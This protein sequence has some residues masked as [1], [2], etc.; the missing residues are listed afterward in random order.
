QGHTLILGWSEQVFTILSELAIAKASEERPSVVILA[1]EDKVE[2]EDGIRARI[3][4]HHLRIVCRSGSPIDLADLEIVS[5]RD[6]RSTIVLAPRVADPDAHV[7]KT[8]LAL[9][10]SEA[11][12]DVRYHIV[13]E[14]NDPANL[15]AA[16]LVGGEEAVV[17]DKRDT[18][19]RL[20]VQAA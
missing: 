10:R 8:V 15:E 14:I 1:E 9:T 4:D 3:G 13:A 11:H 19:S 7:L 20:V 2:M 18:I 17:V 12:R 5:P 16:R 6:A